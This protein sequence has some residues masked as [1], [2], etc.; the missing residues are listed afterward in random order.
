MAV[1]RRRSRDAS[2]RKI[3]FP[4]SVPRPGQERMTAEVFQ[5][6]QD[7]ERLLVQAPTGIGKT[8]AA[9][10]PAVNAMADGLTDKI[11]YLT[12]KTT[13]R[14]AAE[15][16]LGELRQNGLR[17]KSLT[18]TAKE[19]ACLN[20][21]VSCRGEDCGFAR[22]Y[23]DRLADALEELWPEDSLTRDTVERTS[24]S[25]QVCPFELARELM[26]EA[27]VIICDYNHVLDPKAYLRRFFLEV[28]GRFTFLIDEAH[29]LAERA[30]E[31]F[32][33][34][35]NP[36]SFRDLASR[37][38]QDFPE[39][40]SSLSKINKW[41]AAAKKKSQAAGGFLAER[42]GPDSLYPLLEEFL[43]SAGRWTAVDSLAPFREEFLNLCF[44]V[45]D[46]LKIADEYN[47][48]YATIYERKGRDLRLKLFCLDPSGL[49]DRALKRGSCAVLFSATL[50]PMDYHRE[51]LG[52]PEGRILK[53]PSPFPKSNLCLLVCD[54]ISA[55]YRHRRITR[56]EGVG[57]IHALVSQKKGN[58]L[59]FLPSYEYLHL[60]HQSFVREYPALELMAQHPGMSE[61]EKTKFLE[62]FNQENKGTLVGF[63]VMG[64]I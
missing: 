18:L 15:K 9:I 34:E 22:D 10:F 57:G 60:I 29:N 59:V 41:L 43:E 47:E 48:N 8:M 20:G 32:S 62:R 17:I 46:F 33:A 23:Y 11:F 44:R 54:G 2:I 19:K 1:R 31:M 25:H 61:G 53:L 5:A 14:T 40:Y 51:I 27:D 37:L 28:K 64:G 21:V 42:E 24:L 38:K 26:S 50:N 56:A 39:V 49:L 58:Y 45:I 63:A 6:I 4:Y 55:R 7:Q 52:C 13:G 36:G 35:I 12:A 30:R 16:A 3:D